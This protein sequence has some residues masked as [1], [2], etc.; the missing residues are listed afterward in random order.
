MPLITICAI[1]ID[2]YL[3]V[4]WDNPKNYIYSTDIEKCLFKLLW[5]NPKEKCQRN[6]MWQSCTCFQ[7]RFSPIRSR[8]LFFFLLFFSSKRFNEVAGFK[9][10]VFSFTNRTVSA[11]WLSRWAKWSLAVSSHFFLVK[12]FFYV[13]VFFFSFSR[14]NMSYDFFQL[15]IYLRSKK[16]HILYGDDYLDFCAVNNNCCHNYCDLFSITYVY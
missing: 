16:I 14:K 11:L 3:K 10:Y 1:C 9:I 5:N 13:F 12:N 15:K 7:I 8:I 2:L 4:Q 6:S